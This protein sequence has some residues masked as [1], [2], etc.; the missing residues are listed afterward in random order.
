MK[1]LE[2]ISI[3]SPSAPRA[4]LNTTVCVVQCDSDPSLKS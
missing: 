4:M 1:D 3:A 2:E